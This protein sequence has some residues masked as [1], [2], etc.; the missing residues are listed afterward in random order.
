MKRVMVVIDEE[1]HRDYKVWAAR[2]GVSLKD[3][4]AAVL[5]KWLEVP[6]WGDKEICDGKEV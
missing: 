5:L 6:F 1:L 4:M 2:L 3:L